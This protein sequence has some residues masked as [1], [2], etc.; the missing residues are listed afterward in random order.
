MRAVVQKVTAASVEVDGAVVSSIGTGLLCLV[1]L[2]RTDTDADAT[3]LARKILR[4]RAFSK[5]APEASAAAATDATPPLQAA[6]P[7]APAAA[8]WTAS[9]ADIG[10]EVLLVSQF[11]LHARTR[12]ARP[13]FSRAMPPG[14][15][16]GRWRD[17]V[18]LV[19]R[20]AAAAGGK[21][22]ADGAFGKMMHVRIHNDG[23]VTFLL[24]TD[25]AGWGAE[26]ASAS[27]AA[28]EGAATAAAAEAEEE[29][30]EEG[31][32]QDKRRT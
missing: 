9:V 13:D 25:D 32:S 10:G 28:S 20:E 24:D 3:A 15:A 22:V 11:T 17:F 12:R 30:E 29:G 27:A 19:R 5:P 8:P 14:E 1:G 6:A 2:A 16:A 7:A 23:P 31:R 26:T 21:G 4:L 18:A